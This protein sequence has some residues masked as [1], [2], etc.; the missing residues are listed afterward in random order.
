MNNALLELFQR[1]P[2]A[3]NEKIWGLSTMPV[4]RIN[5][6]GKKMYTYNTG[7]IYDYQ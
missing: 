1:K 6:G 5:S 2:D 4:I 7:V 3:V